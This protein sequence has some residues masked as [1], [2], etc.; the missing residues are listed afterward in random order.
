MLTL[1]TPY[2]NYYPTL[3]TPFAKGRRDDGGSRDGETRYARNGEVRIAFT[4]LGGAGGEPLL[5][6]M[7]L[8]VSRFW[9]PQGLVDELVRRG[10]H[11]AAYDQRD[12]GQSTHFPD[13]GTASPIA[14]VLRRRSPAY[15]A[16]DM[17]DDAVA[18][19]DA[20]GWDSAH[21]FGHSMG[22]QLAQRTALRHPG[23]VR[24]ITSSASLPGD[25]G[26]LGAARY[27]RLGTVARLARMKFPEGHDGDIA[28]AVAATRA[29]A[30]PAYPVDEQEV[31]RMAE[32]DQVQRRPRHRGA[33]PPGRR[34]MARRPAVPAPRASPGPARR[35]GS[36]AAPRRRAAHRRGDQRGPAR[37]LARGR[38]L[39]ACRGVPAG[40][41]RG[42]GA[43][44]P[45]RH[46]RAEVGLGL[47][48]TAPTGCS[49]ADGARSEAVAR[50][51]TGGVLGMLAEVKDLVRLL[52]RIAVT[53]VGTVILA[54]GVVLLVTPGPGLVVIA[55][56][57]AV[58]AI[59]YQWARR[60]L[61]AVQARARSAALKAAASRVATASAVLFGVGA[62]G[63][64]VV[65]IF[66]DLLPLSGTGTGVGAAVGG[67]TVLL[68]MAY[69]VREMR[70]AKKA[71]ESEDAE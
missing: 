53:V 61:A 29:I 36:A 62:I 28:L 20:L 55:L 10:F 56:A 46:G 37:H 71:E 70:N 16:E 44:R 18:V 30:S 7:G 35:A 66:T 64:G 39:P 68:T 51:S 48:P 9:W 40:S 26:R 5:L 34:E 58:F 24:S 3:R 38:A 22:G 67:L 59:E 12:A 63:L 31:R 17:T 1:R 19:L 32:R 11:V 27:V 50:G 49:A 21:L 41:R 14:A 6:I 4:D 60:N 42:A 45:G 43:R 15:T 69:G 47:T 8:A 52:R 13:T 25:V 33:K 54:V 65:L 57:L 23:R 2:P